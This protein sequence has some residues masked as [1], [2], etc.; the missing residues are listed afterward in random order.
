MLLLP[1][2]SPS[3]D[4]SLLNDALTDLVLESSAFLSLER[5]FLV[6]RPSHRLSHI[7][8]A[9]TYFFRIN[10]VLSKYL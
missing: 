2:D 10:P 4:D 7:R 1:F 3:L 9:S 8:P 6:A 5:L